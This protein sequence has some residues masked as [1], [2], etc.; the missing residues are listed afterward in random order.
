VREFVDQWLHFTGRV[1]LGTFVLWQVL[2]LFGSCFTEV[3]E[4]LRERGLAHWTFAERHFPEYV[5]GEDEFHRTLTK[6][7]KKGL[8]R[9]GQATGQPQQWSLFSP[10]I[11]HALSF[12]RLEVRWDDDHFEGTAVDSQALEPLVLTGFNE[13]EDVNCFL[14]YKNFRVRKYEELIMPTPIIRGG[15]F[16]PHSEAWRE[17]L[18][19]SVRENG[20]NMK[21]YVRW[22]WEEYRLRH[23]ELPE[24]TQ[25]ILYMHGYEIPQPPGP[26]PWCFIDCGRHPVARWLPWKSDQ[27]GMK[28]FERY[29]PV[30]DRYESVP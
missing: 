16:D 13:P 1:L 15:V 7:H 8:K 26:S 21:A 28:G 2:F 12:G 24:P 25:I 27:S 11:S 5:N 14:R 30:T 4:S 3:E 29:N 17:R 10:N 20:D 19:D 6:V 9:Y 23:H 22:R 18:D